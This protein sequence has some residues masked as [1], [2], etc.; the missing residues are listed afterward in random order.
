MLAN[1]FYYA[2]NGNKSN[3]SFVK[4][5]KDIQLDELTDYSLI[6]KT[7]H[8]PKDEEKYQKFYNS[9]I[10]IAIK[11][12]DFK[13]DTI[14][15]L[16]LCA[17]QIAEKMKTFEQ[18]NDKPISEEF[19][20]TK[21][22]FMKI[23]LMLFVREDSD[24]LIDYHLDLFSEE[25]FINFAILFGLRDKFIK[26]PKFIKEFK[27]LQNFVSTQMVLYAHKQLK[28]DINIKQDKVI[29]FFEMLKNNR[30][31]EYIAKEL[32]IENCFQTIMSESNYS[33]VKGKPIFSGIVMPKFELLEEEYFQ[34]VSKVKLNDY[35]KYLIKYSK[36]K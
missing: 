24:S 2:K 6:L 10:D 23:L 18:T 33:V 32:K 1:L 20:E 3:D 4:Y 19:K 25:D 9:L 34:Y 11:A 26:I 8:F 36:V 14:D 16:E 13:E 27:N 29:T 5:Y 7:L 22:V 30:F 21:T 12:K 35:D 31:K 28:D 17:P 15:E